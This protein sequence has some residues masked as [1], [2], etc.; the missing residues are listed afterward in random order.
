MREELA[1]RYDLEAPDYM[2][3]SSTG[4][5]RVKSFEGFYKWVN[6]TFLPRVFMD[7]FYKNLEP[8]SANW[9]APLKG[10][11]VGMII[12]DDYGGKRQRRVLE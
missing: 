4:F 5:D 12:K 3:D 7:P 2:Y 1:I 8:Q 6:G 9:A 11:N 10:S